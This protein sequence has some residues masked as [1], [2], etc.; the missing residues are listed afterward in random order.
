MQIKIP[1]SVLR[2]SRSG[3]LLFAWHPLLHGVVYT[4]LPVKAVEEGEA[5]I[6]DGLAQCDNPNHATVTCTSG[7]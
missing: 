6:K 4:C 7:T 1:K 2:P 5:I 3:I